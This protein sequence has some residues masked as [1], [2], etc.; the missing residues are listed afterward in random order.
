ML[1]QLTLKEIKENF[2]S[3]KAM[4][5]L[6]GVSLIFTGMSISFISVKELGLMAQSE[7]L[8]TMTKIVIGVALLIAII[9]SS[10]SLSNEREQ[11]TLESLL[12]TPVT[13]KDIILAKIFAILAIWV[14]IYL[15]SVPYL[16]VLG[17][18]TQL[19]VTNIVLV[20]VLGTI[21][22]AI[23][24]MIAISLSIVIRSSKNAMILSIL[25]FIVTASPL[26]LSTTMKKS[27]FGRVF[28][29]IS[30]I[31]NVLN[32]SKEVL[33]R[34][35]AFIDMGPYLIPLL[36]SSLVVVGILIKSIRKLSFEGVE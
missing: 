30:P 36:T 7:I 34:H 12:L 25:I 11:S 29:M 27:G 31:S 3:M 1:K 19:V 24:S 35:I 16:I 9:L 13:N 2:Y 33:I 21:I 22:V 28:D 26:L 23:F 5:W 14:M 15:V 20:F 6:F 10:V 18:G 17:Y 4:L 8:V 32:L